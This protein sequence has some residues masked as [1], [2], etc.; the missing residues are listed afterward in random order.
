MSSP[1]LEGANEEN[2][3]KEITMAAGK[4]SLADFSRE[5]VDKVARRVNGRGSS[6]TKGNG[7]QVVVDARITWNELDGG[8]FKD[9][10][11]NNDDETDDIDWED[12]SYSILDSVS[13]HHL[14]DDGTTAVTVE[15]SESLDSA[16]RKP[17]RRATSEEKELAELVHKVHLLCLLARG[18]IIDSACDDPLIQAS[19]LSLLPS[20]LLKTSGVPKLSA[21]ALSP[22]V[23]WF[24]NNFH[25]RSCVS[26]K[27]SFQKALA[28]ALETR[29]GNPEEVAS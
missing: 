29:E 11:R 3:G 1:W 4:E 6:G 16:K 5:S 18:R 19:L 15:F 14:G 21:N 7:K 12:G 8:K 20:H 13:N 17:V 2:L 10:L 24:H 9:S 23:S 22:L 26:E 27:R 28:F 25:V